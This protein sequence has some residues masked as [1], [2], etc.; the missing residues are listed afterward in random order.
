VTWPHGGVRHLHQKLTCLPLSVL[1]P[2]VQIWSC[3][4]PGSGLDE[5]R[6]FQRVAPLPPPPEALCGG[7]SKVN[8]QE[9]LSSFGDKCLQNGSKN[10]L[11]APRTGMGC[12]HI[13]PPVGQCGLPRYQVPPPV[14]KFALGLG[15]IV[16]VQPNRVIN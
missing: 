1:G 9:T 14:A 13:G 16:K 4:T 2:Y 12:P 15:F 8:F 10:G 7:I 5:N 11:R 3:N 6:V